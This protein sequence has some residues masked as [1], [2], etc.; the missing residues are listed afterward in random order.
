MLIVR[1]K[2]LRFPVGIYFLDVCSL[3]RFYKQ[4]VVVFDLYVCLLHSRAALVPASVCPGAGVC[5]S[6]CVRM[7]TVSG[8]AR[9]E[10]GC[11]DR[12]R[13]TGVPHQPGLAPRWKLT[14]TSEPGLHP[15]SGQLPTSP[16]LSPSAP[17][18]PRRQSGSV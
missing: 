15:A 17:T 1:E 3:G 2:S 13:S 16:A 6:V 8:L 5:V 18:E 7:G 14:A 10:P 4:G 9:E 12:P 11:T